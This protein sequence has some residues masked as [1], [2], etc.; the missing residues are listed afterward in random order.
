MISRNS[1]ET[2]LSDLALDP[3]HFRLSDQDLDPFSTYFFYRICIFFFNDSSSDMG[4]FDSPQRLVLY[5]GQP[6]RYVD[7]V[8]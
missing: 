7:N 3:C 8:R 6:L 4:G 2:F 5:I 1:N